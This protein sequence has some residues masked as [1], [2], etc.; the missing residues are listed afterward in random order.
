MNH[1]IKGN[2]FGG[3]HN[4]EEQEK[5]VVVEDKANKTD[6]V[7]SYNDLLAKKKK[8]E[9]Q[10]KINKYLSIILERSG[11]LKSQGDKAVDRFGKTGDYYVD[12]WQAI[13]SESPVFLE[14]NKNKQARLLELLA[15]GDSET[16]DSEE[17]QKTLYNEFP[18]IADW[19]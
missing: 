4:I 17:V 8:E 10:A 5:T 7:K 9:D 18:E 16:A 15:G 11:R 1:H 12:V 3:Q 14:G 13:K 19:T 2:I 6:V